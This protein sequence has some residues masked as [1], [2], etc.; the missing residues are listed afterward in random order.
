ML[1]L[2]VIISV[3][4]DII[5]L[6]PVIHVA[7][8]CGHK[9]NVVQV[10]RKSTVLLDLFNFFEITP[11]ISLD[12]TLS[13]Q[14]M[15]TFNEKLFFHLNRNK[16]A[17]L[18][19]DVIVV[20]G[21]SAVAFDV[22][23]WAFCEKISIAHI[24]SGIGTK[25]LSDSFFEKGHQNLIDRI[26]TL[27]FVSTLQDGKKIRESHS[28]SNRIF[29]IGNTAID[30]V[31]YTLKKIEN[32]DLIEIANMDPKIPRF[33]KSYKFVTVAIEYK[34]SIENYCAEIC[35]IIMDIVKTHKDIRVIF[36]VSQHISNRKSIERLLGYHPSILVCDPL[37]YVAFTALLSRSGLILTDSDVI[38]E[39]GPTLRRPIFIM[40]DRTNF[41]EGI[42]RGF[43][44]LVGINPTHIQEE[45]LNAIQHG[46]LTEQEN[47]YGDGHASFRMVEVLE[48]H[49][50]Q[51]LYVWS[52]LE[53]EN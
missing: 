49:S 14:S 34:E 7:R 33:L 42:S 20:L 12:V 1:T 16:Q 10:G 32:F 51:N 5:K 15:N 52:S 48:S 19:S 28:L 44:K 23:Y 13:T 45:V 21:D 11:N 26:A 3:R 43:S 36:P 24:H 2:T 4:S 41:P 27:H 47:P 29:A 35:K 17:L 8:A 53:T 25:H 40:S 30:A 37:S 6:S 38:Q 39:E 18:S 31:H 9:V 46:L 50:T 22:A